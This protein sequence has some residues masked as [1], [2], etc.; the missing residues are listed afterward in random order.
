MSVFEENDTNFG[1]N[2]LFLNDDSEILLDL[3]RNC[4]GDGFWG[5]PGGKIKKGETIE[6]AIVREGKEECRVIIP[7]KAIKVVNIGQTINSRHM[8]QI[9]AVVHSY[10]G[11]IKNG[12]PDLCEKLEYFGKDNLPG[13]LFLGT[14]GNIKKFFSHQ[15]YTLDANITPNAIRSNESVP[16]LIN[17][18]IVDDNDKILLTRNIGGED[19]QN[20]GL[21]NGRVKVGETIEEASTRIAYETLG[22]IVPEDEMVF[23]NFSMKIENGENIIQIGVIVRHKISEY[24]SPLENQEAQYIH[25]KSFPGAIAIVN[26][27]NLKNYYAGLFYSETPIT[28]KLIYGPKN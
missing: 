19:F 20:W 7:E 1:A 4:F 21:H 13:N 11:K 17:L 14:E 18:I 12:I 28:Q 16:I 2:L 3:R 22:L 23:N 6:Q 15:N 5:L 25:R 27:P 24:I 8:L 9:G 26:N 10:K